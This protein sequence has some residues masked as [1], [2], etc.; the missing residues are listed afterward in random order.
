VAD[1]C[2][3]ETATNLRAFVCREGRRKE[4][5]ET[6]NPSGSDFVLKTHPYHGPQVW[7]SAVSQVCLLPPWLAEKLT[8]MSY[9]LWNCITVC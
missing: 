8:L 3:Q 1:V 5:L 4:G 9:I 6:V 2:L 7:R